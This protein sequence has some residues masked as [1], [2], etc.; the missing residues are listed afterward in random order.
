MDLPGKSSKEIF[1]KEK[2]EKEEK[3]TFTEKYPSSYFEKISKEKQVDLKKKKRKKIIL[4][5]LMLI[6]VAAWGA[7]MFWAES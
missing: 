1:I 2:K 7:F 3:K 4:F 6:A 5:I